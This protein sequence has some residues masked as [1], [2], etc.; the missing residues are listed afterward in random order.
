MVLQH[1][2]A[3]FLYLGNASAEEVVRTHIGLHQNLIQMSSEDF[4]DLKR[5]IAPHTKKPVKD[6]IMI[7]GATHL[8]LASYRNHLI[9]CFAR[10]AL[11]A[12]SVNAC[13]E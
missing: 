10:V 3:L 9:H 1:L 5:I 6:D 11:V 8:M 13:C 12:L 4:V 7:T 2:F